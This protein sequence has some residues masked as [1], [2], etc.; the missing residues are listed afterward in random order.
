MIK[1]RI[2]TSENVTPNFLV[3]IQQ[4]V[5]YGQEIMGLL[6]S[7]LHAFR[8]RAFWTILLLVS[9]SFHVYIFTVNWF[10]EYLYSKEVLCAM[11]FPN[12]CTFLSF[13]MSVPCTGLGVGPCTFPVFKC[14]QNWFN[15]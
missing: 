2:K 3:E 6:P 11:S 4:F 12:V 9:Y 7:R 14:T 10:D 15:E 5:Q 8:F 13:I 1:V